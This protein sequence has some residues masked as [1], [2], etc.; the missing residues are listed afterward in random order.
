MIYI[1]ISLV[2]LACLLGIY[3]KKHLELEQS[4]SWAKQMFQKLH[5]KR[6]A[7]NKQEAS[8]VEMLL[9][10]P[11]QQKTLKETLMS[12]EAFFENGDLDEAEKLYVQVLSLDD[13]HPEAN[14][15]LGLIYIK[16]QLA[17]KAEA[18]FRKILAVSPYD[19]LATSNLALA[20]YLQRNYEEAKE[21]YLK[22]ITLDP[23]R[24]P[25]YISLAHVY[26][27]LNDYDAAV[28]AIHKAF[29]LEPQQNEYRLLLAETYADM[30]NLS[31]ART[32]AQNI[33][34]HDSEDTA[35]RRNARTLLKRI[36]N[37][38]DQE[39]EGPKN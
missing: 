29:T 20:L 4:G 24:A 28:Q 26:R 7:A 33:L 8:Q 2:S 27:E 15:R 13:N 3:W 12:A 6:Q 32:I 34:K 14:M 22:A 23:G 37:K 19:A 18:I 21:I 9:L 10:T 31:A 30:N 36:D 39:D 38:I 16:K 11:E 35:L 5:I 17:K 25:R 1:L